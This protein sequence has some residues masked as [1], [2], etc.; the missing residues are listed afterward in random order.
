MNEKILKEIL[1]ELKNIHY[2][3]DRLDAFYVIVNK[4]K[5]K[6]EEEKFKEEVIKC[7]KK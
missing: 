2:H 5:L 1:Q 6:K 4:T 3:L 7:Q